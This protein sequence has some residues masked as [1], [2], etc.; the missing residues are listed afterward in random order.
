MFRLRKLRAF[1]S[2]DVFCPCNTLRGNV[3]LDHR[4]NV[5]VQL[6]SVRYDAH[7]L[8]L[9]AYTRI[10]ACLYL[11]STVGGLCIQHQHPAPQHAAAYQ[12]DYEPCD[13]TRVCEALLYTRHAHD[14][15]QQP[16]DKAEC[17]LYLHLALLCLLMFI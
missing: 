14:R 11:L 15:E 16:N 9:V 4:G 12:A 3:V 7:V 2:R 13:Q 1:S 6:L 5:S 8:L 10:I 17:S